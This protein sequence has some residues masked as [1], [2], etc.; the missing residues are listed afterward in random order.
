MG[1]ATRIVKI[2]K[3]DIHGVMDQFVD[4]GLL[5]KQY[6][7]DME[8]ALNQKEAKLARKIAL[9]NQTQKEY[10]KYD[11]QYRALDH[12]LTVAVEKG[13]DD[14]ARMLIRKTKPLES[15]CSELVDQMATLDEEISR[16]NKYLEQQR[17]QYE[18][19][20]IR[21][22]EYFHRT[23][24]QVRDKDILEIVPNSIPGELSEDEIELELLKRKEA[25]NPN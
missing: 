21:S 16:F 10:H 3:A 8:E 22:A 25:L 5:L 19:L 13:K 11:Q 2:F 12:D 18:Q 6:L 7:R 15:L 17:L 9:R 20:K 4:Q 23:E 14:I 1:I 24:M